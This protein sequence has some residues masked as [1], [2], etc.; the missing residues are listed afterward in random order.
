MVDV[1]KFSGVPFRRF[2]GHRTKS[3]AKEVA[4]R[5][6]K[7]GNFVRT[8]ERDGKWEVFSRTTKPQRTGPLADA[9]I[10]SRSAKRG[11]KGRIG[12]AR[13]S[14]R[15]RR[16]ATQKRAQECRV[17]LRE[18]REKRRKANEDFRK[19]LQKCRTAVKKTGRV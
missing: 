7:D 6:R 4:E 13:A 2:S 1:L 9:V 15:K 3:K 19:A 14:A 10:A 5:L 16:E 11:V 8:I 12:K 17:A 18:A